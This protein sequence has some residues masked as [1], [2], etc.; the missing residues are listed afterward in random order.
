MRVL[1]NNIGWSDLTDLLKFCPQSF[2]ES[3]GGTSWDVYP[4]KQNSWFLCHS[5]DVKTL[6][7]FLFW[8]NLDFLLKLKNGEGRGSDVDVKSHCK[9][10]TNPLV[11]KDESHFFQVRL[12]LGRIKFGLISSSLY[13]KF[14]YDILIRFYKCI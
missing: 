7:T 9:N 5:V 4:R 3:P 12:V 11:S 2:T 8:V 1:S 10:E 13:T 6:Y 14:P